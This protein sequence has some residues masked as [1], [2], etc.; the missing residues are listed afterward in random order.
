MS[1]PKHVW[2]A[3]T[4]SIEQEGIWN[5]FWFYL[6][7]LAKN[8]A[9]QQLLYRELSSS[10]EDGEGICKKRGVQKV[11]QGRSCHRYPK[12]LPWN[13]ACTTA[14]LRLSIPHHWESCP[15]NSLQEPE[16]CVWPA[17]PAACLGSFESITLPVLCHRHRWH[18]THSHLQNASWFS[19]SP[20][21][22]GGW[23]ATGRGWERRLGIATLCLTRG[24]CGSARSWAPHISWSQDRE[25][26]KAQEIQVPP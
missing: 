5:K 3:T 20:F 18:R 4:C 23:G 6:K 15:P 26:I 25:G 13:R 1:L 2:A 10:R 9:I 21:S 11:L 22:A 7:S 24:T 12:V 8:S 16:S 17:A 14:V 19:R